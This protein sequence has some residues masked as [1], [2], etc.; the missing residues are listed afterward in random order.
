MLI[1]SLKNQKYFDLVNKRGIKF[2]N[3]SSVLVLAKNYPDSLNTQGQI[4]FGMKVS[5]KLGNA[6]IRNKIKRRIR[7]LV[8]FISKQMNPKLRLGLIVVPRKGFEKI[9][10]STLVNEFSKTLINK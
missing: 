3:A 5:K 4:I 1:S 7:H 9:A 6:V 2:H 8:N 10:F